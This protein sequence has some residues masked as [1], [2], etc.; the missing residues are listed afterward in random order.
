MHFTQHSATVVNGEAS[1]TFTLW[2]LIT[3]NVNPPTLTAKKI[4]SMIRPTED[5][6]DGQLNL[7][8]GYSD[9][10]ED[11]AAEILAQMVPQHAFWSSVVMLHPDR[12]KWTLELLATALRLA[13]LVEMR[14]KQA[15]ACRRPAERSPQVQPIIL[16]PGHG[17]LP[18]GHAT[19]AHIVAR[20]LY[21][22]VS[23]RIAPTAGAQQA[24]REQLMRQ[25]ARIA[26]N[27]T[28]AGVHYPVDSA[29]GQLLGLTLAEYFIARLA[30]AGGG[31]FAS[32]TFDGTKFGR[33]TDFNFRDQYDTATGN[34]NTLLAYAI[35]DAGAT[36]A[37]P[38]LYL[39]W[40]WA[41]AFGE[42]P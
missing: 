5:I 12:N 26:I 2:H 22:L 15:L 33:S 19:E 6:F 21:E 25:A 38:G 3:A 18:S 35:P 37:G 27:R 4:V 8:D 30:T 13:N 17:A 24:L 31:T 42:W 32:W 36:N 23:P 9:L 34:R 1:A 28:V 7:V 39:N 29:A 16:T 20:V 40:L 11:R 14:F 10:R 41:K